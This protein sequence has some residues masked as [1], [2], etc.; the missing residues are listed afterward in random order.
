MQIAWHH[1]EVGT[2]G[3][4]TTYFWLSFLNNKSLFALLI[5][6]SLLVLI[7]VAVC[8][9]SVDVTSRSIFVSVS[10][11]LFKSIRLFSTLHFLWSCES[12][13]TSNNSLVCTHN[14]I[15]SPASPTWAQLTM[16]YLVDFFWPS[17][18]SPITSKSSRFYFINAFIQSR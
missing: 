18:V 2:V 11:N 6:W 3:W 1:T 14:L 9:H 16:V 7:D 13:F 10:C 17:H 5:Y 12:N 4:G 8:R 15:G